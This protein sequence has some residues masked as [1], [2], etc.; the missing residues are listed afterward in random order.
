MELRVFEMSNSPE[1]KLPG[2]LA[3]RHDDVRVVFRHSWVFGWHAHVTSADGTVLLSFPWTDD[4]DELLRAEHPLELPA[5]VTEEG[6]DDLDQGWWGQVVVVGDDVYVAE[7]D[8]DAIL[9]ARPP[10][11]L[12]GAA[13]GV[14]HVNDVE[15]RWNVVNRRAWD[16][17]WDRARRAC[18]QG[19]PAPIGKWADGHGERMIVREPRAPRVIE[20]LRSRLRAKLRR[21]DEHRRNA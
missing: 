15:V 21:R 16:A 2:K 9:D 1:I 19:Q 6:W 3:R 10:L 18:L 4:V 14:V 7:T 17:A 20:R 11:L 5:V 12:R 13:P 8:F